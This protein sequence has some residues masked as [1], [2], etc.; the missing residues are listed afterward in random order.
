MSHTQAQR[1]WRLPSFQAWK[2]VLCSH[3]R[4]CSPGRTVLPYS[5][6]RKQEGRPKVVNHVLQ[7]KAVFRSAAGASILNCDTVRTQI[8]YGQMLKLLICNSGPITN[9]EDK[10]FR[11][12]F[13]P[14]QSD[15]FPKVTSFLTTVLY[16]HSV[17]HKGNSE[18]QDYLNCKM[19]NTMSKTQSCFRL[20]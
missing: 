4:C 8:P 10:H 11:F 9:R 16:S 2:S 6:N 13:F 17:L 20:E 3:V 18:R 5:S 19:C 7:G 12:P 15:Y 14:H 1:R